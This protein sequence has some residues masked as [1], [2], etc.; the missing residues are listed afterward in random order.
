MMTNAFLVSIVELLRLDSPAIAEAALWFDSKV[1]CIFWTVA[2][3]AN[4]DIGIIAVVL[5][6]KKVLRKYSSREVL[7]II[8]VYC[9]S[10]E[11]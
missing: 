1:I 5:T 10:R 11:Y 6:A 7:Y 3:C 4:R 2:V 8:E 9:T